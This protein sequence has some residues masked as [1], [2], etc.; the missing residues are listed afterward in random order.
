MA[1]IDCSRPGSTGRLLGLGLMFACLALPAQA[2][3][4]TT[5]FEI[6]VG[7]PHLDPTSDGFDI[8]SAG[9][10]VGMGPGMAV[11]VELESYLHDLAV[12]FQN[13][14]FPDPVPAGA[15]GPVVETVDGRRAIRV[16]M[17][18]MNAELGMDKLG[19]RT[20]NCD[21]PPQRPRLLLNSRYMFSGD[22]V[23]NRGYQNAAHELFHAVQYATKFKRVPSPCA[24]GTWITEGTADAVGFDYA[25]RLRHI[26][27]SDWDTTEGSSWMKAWGARA[28]Y[29]TLP[30]KSP[31]D[32]TGKPEETWDYQTSAFW[33]DIAELTYAKKHGGQHPQSRLAPV[34]YSYLASLFA[35][36]PAGLGSQNELAWLDEWLKSYPPIS[37]DL[38]RI[39][40]QF[41]G[42]AADHMWRRIPPIRGLQ[43]AREPRWLKYLF[44]PCADVQLTPTAPAKDAPFELVP[45]SARCVN[46]TVNGDER[47]NEL[48]IQ[49][50]DFTADEQ[51][52]L[53]LS[54]I[55]G[56][57]AG[58]A[59]MR[60]GEAGHPDAG[61]SYAW[62]RMPIAPGKKN[63]FIIANVGKTARDTQALSG[64]LNFSLPRWTSSME[65][66]EDSP[67]SDSSEEQPKSPG[68]AA[69]R[70]KALRTAPSRNTATATI[71]G[72]G[73]NIPDP[74]CDAGRRSRNLCGPRL[75]IVLSHDRGGIPDPALMTGAGGLLAQM[76]GVAADMEET[77]VGSISDFVSQS[78]ALAQFGKGE[79]VTIAIPLIDYGAGGSFSNALISVNKAGDVDSAGSLDSLNPAP[80][81]DGIHAPNGSVTITEYSP[82][83]LSGTFNAQLVDQRDRHGPG[84]TLLRAADNISGSFN[85]PAPWRGHA[86]PDVSADSP[87]MQGMRSDLVDMLQALP[88]DQRR[89]LIGGPQLRSLC[90][91][92]T[93][94][95]LESLGIP[96]ACEGGGGAA[97][98]AGS[99]CD[100]DCRTWEYTQSLPRCGRECDAKWHAW[101]CGPYLQTGL[102][103][104]D[105]ETQRYMAEAQQLGV[106]DNVWKPWVMS[107]KYSP[108]D[109]RSGLWEELEQH[110]GQ[111]LMADLP[112]QL[113]AVEAEQTE[114]AQRASQYDAETL[115]YKAALEQA[116]YSATEVSGLTSNFAASAAAVR[117]IYWNDVNQRQAGDE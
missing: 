108:A 16:Y 64:K 38:A 66:E 41:V 93:S 79:V 110:R 61:K 86:A 111:D 70:Q 43:G 58:Q 76:G 3:W 94:E 83:F 33:R 27:T 80:D 31:L 46:V 103:E 85:V 72:R 48:V 68:E 23:T 8:P 10:L 34:D 37:R 71:A 49:A 77:P 21:E 115:R 84:N 97:F 53:W 45:V 55:G 30:Y 98:V 82:E 14:G 19:F 15:I 100:C 35:T 17:L 81:A 69:E 74:G 65:S 113:E 25:R 107:F 88:P 47:A 7:K 36:R 106:S 11:I 59:D 39:Y 18:D 73:K 112:G 87:M 20:G 5:E 57:I 26:S 54:A 105:A 50:N 40:A 90:K 9:S 116:G 44:Q 60:L 56:K 22:K 67:Q 29:V 114:Q 1:G 117:Q 12:A 63:F 75:E 89:S 62:W 24:Q 102:G 4:Q 109:I 91:L 52:Q 51:N 104:L 28:Y 92:L 42:S 6:F 2:A 78:Q 95:D 96:G 99:M 101:S 13:D 32:K